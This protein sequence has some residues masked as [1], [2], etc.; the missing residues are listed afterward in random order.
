MFF[1]GAYWDARVAVSFWM[2][3]A[4]TVVLRRLTSPHV[5]A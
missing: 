3:F 1:N 5:G 4:M 2:L